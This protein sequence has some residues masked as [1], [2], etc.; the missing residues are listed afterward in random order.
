M[1]PPNENA[2]EQQGEQQERAAEQQAGTQEKAGSEKEERFTRAEAET[3]LKEQMAEADKK[4]IDP[5]R[6]KR[7]VETFK[8]NPELYDAFKREM[9]EDSTS[10]ELQSLKRELFRE[11][12]IRKYD[13]QEDDQHLLSGNSE[14]EIE[15]N[16]KR[17]AEIRKQSGK[18]KAGQG[19]SEEAG[20]GNRAHFPK[21]TKQNR[22]KPQTAVEARATFHDEI[23]ASR[24]QTGRA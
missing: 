4:R 24:G 6:L 15:A 17:V 22:S 12:L 8:K 5:E 1:P 20:A 18:P 11:R 23:D 14:D 2:A 13:L 16:A 21:P 7:Q 10:D 9:G 19:E 3:M